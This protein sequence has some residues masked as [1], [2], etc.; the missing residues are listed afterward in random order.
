MPALFGASPYLTRWML[1]RHFIHGDDIEGDADGR[2]N[3]GK[4]LQPLLLAQ[5]AEDLRLEVRPN[6]ADD[7]VRRGLIGCTRDGE[8]ICPTRGPG[9]IE[10]KCVFDYGV[11][12][13]AWAGGKRPPRANELQLQQQ[14][15]VG[16]GDTPHEWGMLAVWVCGDVKYYERKPIPKVVDAIDV[17]AKSFF[18]DVI[19]KR[20]GK[21]FGEPIEVPLLAEAFPT[22]AG[23]SIAIDDEKL[24]EIAVQYR[25]A[26]EQEAG[27]KRGAEPLRAKLLAAAEGAGE[28]L[29]PE[30]VR[31]RINSGKS[32]TRIKVFVP[33]DDGI[34]SDLLA[35]G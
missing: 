27:G 35:A 7:Y 11:W 8:I 28:I 5:A 12:M 9:S 2:M 3:W 30:G 22:E 6:T 29:L 31:V 18:D 17:E 4:K 14:M 19:A 15:I 1:L 16:D 25:D 24:A 20:E 23:R 21:P 33:G 13:S 34:P 26:K 10:T 32:G